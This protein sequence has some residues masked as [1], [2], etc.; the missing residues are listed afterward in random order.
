MMSP[1][2]LV[3][4]AHII[5]GALYESRRNASNLKTAAALMQ[6]DS[7]PMSHDDGIVADHFADPH[8]PNA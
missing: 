4:W 7:K 6:C 2:E 8:S 3:H 5:D 1:D